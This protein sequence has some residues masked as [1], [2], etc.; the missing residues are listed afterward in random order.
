[1][2]EVNERKGKNGMKK[3]LVI[4]DF[5]GTLGDT[6]GVILK[7][8]QAT[9][10]EL[11]LPERTDGQCASMIGLRLDEIP[12][13]LFPECSG[14][15]GVFA[16]TYRRL[17]YTFDS[18]DAVKLYPGV[19]STLECLAEKGHVLTIASSRSRAS[20]VRYVNDLGLAPLFGLILG[21]DDVEHAKPDPEPV[22]KTLE[23]F[24][25]NPED[26][27][28][29]GDA[30]Y[31]ILMG[32]RAGVATCGVTYGNGSVESLQEAGADFVIDN[33]PALLNLV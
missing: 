19:A 27:L 10:R 7:T 32:R 9:I 8:M 2:C 23:H 33:F 26:A 25:R 12:A 28:V 22:L 18:K 21:A 5:D 29:V 15:E 30:P 14:L 4:L 31:D 3:K 20:L 6:A 16:E 1:M 17:F 24:G 13:V 11:G